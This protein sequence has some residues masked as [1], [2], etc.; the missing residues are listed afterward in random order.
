MYYPARTNKRT[1]SSTA[2]PL[3]HRAETQRRSGVASMAWGVSKRD[4]H[5]GI[6]LTSEYSV[7]TGHVTIEAFLLQFLFMA[8]G[9]RYT[10]LLLILIFAHCYFGACAMVVMRLLCG[11]M[12]DIYLDVAFDDNFIS[13]RNDLKKAIVRGVKSDIKRLAGALMAR[14]NELKERASKGYPLDKA[15]ELGNHR[16]DLGDLGRMYV[17]RGKE[18][19]EQDK[20]IAEIKAHL[21]RNEKVGVGVEINQ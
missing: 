13:L 3:R 4:F 6:A 2:C 21:A 7:L 17:A 20:M 1:T 5:T 12:M 16:K 11:D 10:K 8:G 14:F 15:K 19:D 9:N 18:R